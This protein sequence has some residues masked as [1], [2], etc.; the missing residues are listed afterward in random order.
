M[1]IINTILLL[2]PTLSFA[3][4]QGYHPEA[5]ALVRRIVADVDSLK[6]LTA[7]EAHEHD[8]DFDL[9]A[10]DDELFGRD[11]IGA[12]LTKRKNYMQCPVCAQPCTKSTCKHDGHKY[13]CWDV[14]QR[15]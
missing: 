9:Y 15:H 8:H 1:Q 11:E 6:Q 5:D 2:I 13:N 7:R 10:R 3:L 4:A 14:R 12:G